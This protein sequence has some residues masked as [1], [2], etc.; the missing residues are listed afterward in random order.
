MEG[1]GS[2]SV[3]TTDFLIVLFIALNGVT[4]ASI[5][6]LVNAKWR[7]HVRFV[8]VS[9]AGLFPVAF[10]LLLILLF[11]GEQTFQ[12]L[13]AA[14][15]AGG[16]EVHLNA[17]H[18]YTFLV[19]RQIVGF[20]VVAGMYGLFI[21][22]QRVAVDDPTYEN[23]RKFRNVALLIPFFYVLYGTMIAWDFEMTMV[24]NWHSASYGLYVWVGMFHFFLAFMAIFT[25]ILKRSGKLRVEIPDRIMNYFA[26]MMLAFTILWTYFFFTQYL[27]IWYG[28]LPEEITR[29]RD[30]MD[31]DLGAIWWT[32]VALKFV[33]P[34]CCLVLTPFRH[35]QYAIVV[36]ASGI[37][38]GTWLERYTWVSGS[39][40]PEYYH[41]PMTSGFDVGVT[42]LV[43][44]LAFVSIRWTLTRNGLLKSS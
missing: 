11:N 19:V 18:N 22:Y 17:W 16:H 43:A 26:Q 5:L 25:F 1:F 42:L 24:P 44:A 41:I 7:E 3:L 37:V 29:F 33:I 21:K 34:L 15:H 23:K 27:I 30:M 9:L 12:W 4:L 38:V 39:V 35:N 8:S 2:W 13:G 14:H 28:R 36:I 20:L 32:F 40:D 31:N 6:H 10:V